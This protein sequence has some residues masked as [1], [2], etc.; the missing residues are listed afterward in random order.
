LRLSLGF[1]IECIEILGDRALLLLPVSPADLTGR[2]AA[3]ATGI[4]LHN[5]GIDGEALTPSPVAIAAHTTRSK[6]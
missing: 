2:H 6:M 1:S 3:I 5:A 4:G